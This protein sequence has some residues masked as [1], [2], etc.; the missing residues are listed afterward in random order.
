[1]CWKQVALTNSTLMSMMFARLLQVLLVGGVGLLCACAPKGQSTA[2]PNERPAPAAAVNVA[3]EAPESES[4]E[5]APNTEATKVSGGRFQSD[6][7]GNILL[8]S[9]SR[10]LKLLY[11]EQRFRWTARALNETLKRDAGLAYQGFFFDAQNG[12]TQ[13]SS[14]WSD[15]AKKR[16]KPLGWPFYDADAGKVILDKGA[17]LALGY[18]VIILGDVDPG[19]PYWRNEYWEWLEAWVKQGGG[20]ILLAGAAHNPAGYAKNE[21]F[22][23]MCPIRLELA[24][25]YE[26]LVDRTVLKY[27]ARTPDGRDH[28]LFELSRDEARRDELFGMEVDDKFQPGE[29]HGIYWYQITGGPAE[30]ATV[31]ARVASEGQPADKGEP[32]IVTREY[33][34][35]RVL[36]LGTDEFHYWRQWVGD[37]YFAR[38]F[39][40]A[41]RW[42]ANDP[43]K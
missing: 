2:R 28:A 5:V 41:I 22:A 12:W 11:I 43:G 10:E 16:V 25:G 29:L 37:F 20:L 17:F 39:Q 4:A 19:S 26:F 15:D 31:L 14:I 21:A 34:T 30:G 18:D 3:T 36:Y 8:S 38:F 33:G 13:P 6:K 7:A 27:I 24:E 23:R 40:N 32:L 9:Y 42:A 1:M 35:G